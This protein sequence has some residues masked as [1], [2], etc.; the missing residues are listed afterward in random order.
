MDSKDV[1]MIQEYGL[2]M[3]CFRIQE[4][5]KEGYSISKTSNDGYPVQI[6]QVYC[7]KMQKVVP[8]EQPEQEEKRTRKTKPQS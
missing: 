4:L 1:V 8:T 7:T 2:D 3:F 5:A 6:G